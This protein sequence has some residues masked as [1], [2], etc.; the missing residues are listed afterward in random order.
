LLVDHL[1]EHRHRLRDGRLRGPVE[2][3]SHRALLVVRRH[4]DD[5]APE[6]RVEQVGGGEQEL[7][8]EGLHTGSL[9]QRAG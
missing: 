3:E 9:A 2:D 1:A 4:Q 5:R 6:V 8:L 7:A